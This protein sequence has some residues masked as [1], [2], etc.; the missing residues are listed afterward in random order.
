MTSK[1]ALMALLGALFCSSVWAGNNSVSVSPSGAG[2]SVAFGSNGTPLASSTTVSPGATSGESLI[3]DMFKAP[4]PAGK[5]LDLAATRAI[6][7]ATV[8]RTVARGHG[9]I[10]VGMAAYDI[11]KDLRVKENTGGHGWDADP[12]TAEKDM[13]I[14]QVEASQVVGTGSTPY[15]AASTFM[16]AYNRKSST[17]SET[18]SAGYG[19]T[20]TISYELGAPGVAPNTWARMVR[21]VIG[22][23]GSAGSNWCGVSDFVQSGIITA[24]A[25]MGKACP[26]M[27]DGSPGVK[28]LDGLCPT[29]NY[30]PITD[31]QA[32]DLFSKNAPKAQAPKI[33]EELLK[34]DV[35]FSPAPS[36]KIEGQPKVESDPKVRTEVGPDGKTKTTTTKDVYNITYGN[37]SYTWNVTTVTVNSDGSSSEETK[38]DPEVTP[39]TDP[40]MPERP[41]LYKQKY[42]DGIAGVWDKEM[43][44]IKST[45]IFSFLYSLN[46][47]IGGASCPRWTFPSGRVLGIDVGGDLSVPCNVWFALR[48]I[49]VVSALLLARRLV[50]GG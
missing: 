18:G 48:A 9:Y 1:F 43:A 33:V 17:Y 22:Y 40:T 6:P 10:Q 15:M 46:P 12:G 44:G 5:S 2:Y 7:W 24:V 38:P 4:G 32:A 25:T 30:Q 11:Y 23:R 8:A 39:P 19:C 14:W 35:E 21:T 28:G 36:V 13:A 42:P 29:G 47:N 34:R 49:I 45:P 26:T 41:K 37:N 27:P 50:F 20:Q 16:A 3:K 31:D